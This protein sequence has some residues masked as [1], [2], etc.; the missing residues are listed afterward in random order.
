MLQRHWAIPQK[1]PSWGRAKM[2]QKGPFWGGLFASKTWG[3]PPQNGV[4]LSFKIKIYP[5]EG[6]PRGGPRR[7]VP[8]LEGR[9]GVGTF[10]GM[11]RV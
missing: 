8:K 5:K 2:G 11:A 4:V 6:Y 7:G 10:A 1:T 3:H 9:G